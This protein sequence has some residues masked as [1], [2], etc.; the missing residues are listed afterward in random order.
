M[1]LLFIGFKETA[2]AYAISSAGIAI[3]IAKRWSQGL[4]VNSGSDNHKYKKKDAWKWVGCY[5]NFYYGIKFSKMFFESKET[6]DDI[7]SQISLHNANVGR[8]VIR[9]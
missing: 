8:M 9:S 4:I 3:S 6:S 5:H 7:H 2:F 1:L